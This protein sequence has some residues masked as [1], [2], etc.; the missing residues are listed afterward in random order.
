MIFNKKELQGKL[1]LVK[2]AVAK[3]SLL[4]ILSMI[5]L[6]VDGNGYT[7]TA[8]NGTMEL[9]AAGTCES[10]ETASI[11]IPAD[12]FLAM[13]KS[14]KETIKLTIKDGK[15]KSSGGRS[16][17]NVS[18]LSGENYPSLT[19]DDAPYNDINLREVI[20]T[21]HKAAPKSDVRYYLNGV[22][23]QS[24][25]GLITAIG[26][27]G[28]LC[29]V[30][31]IESDI[32][33][34]NFIIPIQ[35]AEYLAAIHTDGFYC[36]AGMFSA[37]NNDLALKITGKVIDGKFPDWKRIMSPGQKS[38]TINRQELIQALQVSQTVSNTG[39]IRMVS[40]GDAM[41]IIMIE[42]NNSVESD[43]TSEGDD[44]DSCYNA[45]LL[46]IAASMSDSENITFNFDETRM[47]SVNGNS[48]FVLAPLR[49]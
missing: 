41:R 47:M 14:S 49:N 1:D 42:N 8:N 22:C 2:S 33:G 38:L 31:S 18:F 27:D 46:T 23:I 25:D 9:V 39:S 36:T 26:T 10:D 21:I 6:S 35:T 30:N 15:L 17:F 37:V 29:A 4:P 16:N 44:M 34:V 3:T 24:G 12:M 32:D 13:V 48:K 28:S 40:K 7:V 5:K 45:K 20:G 43:L 19:I 11:C